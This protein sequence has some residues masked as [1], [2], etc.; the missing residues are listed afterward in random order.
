MSNA[1]HPVGGERRSFRC[2]FG[3][4]REVDVVWPAEEPVWPPAEELVWPPAEEDI[5]ACSVVHLDGSDAKPPRLET[6][7]DETP[8]PDAFR[9][10]TPR[11]QA[12]PA[13]TPRLGP[14]RVEPPGV[15]PVSNSV[16][17]PVPIRLEPRRIKPTFGDC[18]PLGAAPQ[19]R[20]PSVPMEPPLLPGP[21]L[22]DTRSV[23]RSAAVSE[24]EEVPAVNA[25][26]DDTMA[27]AADATAFPP[28]PFSPAALPR[29]PETVG[30]R[31]SAWLAVFFAAA[32]ALVTFAEYRGVGMLPAAAPEPPP[33]PAEVSVAE[34]PAPA[35]RVVPPSTLSK[36]AAADGVATAAPARPVPAPKPKLARAPEPTPAPPPRLAVVTPRRESEPV[37]PD[38]PRVTVDVADR[39]VLAAD[40]MEPRVTPTPAAARPEPRPAP[41]AGVDAP[42]P[43]VPTLAPVAAAKPELLAKAAA[44]PVAARLSDVA[45][46]EAGIQSTLTRFRTAYSQ[47]NASAARDVWPSVDARALERAFHSLKSQDLR[48]D[49]CTMT[50]TGARAHAACKGRAVYVPRIGDQSPRFTAREWNF[51]LRKAD[52]RWTIASARSL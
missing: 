26:A 38:T 8:R 29:D 9:L 5:A 4:V 11:E 12:P 47:L 33:L 51:E 21:A 6:P 20:P 13:E 15:E 40:R 22:P 44:T 2:T 28:L 18:R 19:V 32:C 24:S 42:P 1:E 45:S 31:R 46:D 34:V 35:N 49:S 17:G 7:L 16:D 43:P 27:A 30:A 50:V 14:P 25:P 10:E 23:V 41:A 3:P 36:P 48:F 39:G 37:R 52:E